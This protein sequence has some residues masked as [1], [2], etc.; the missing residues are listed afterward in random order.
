MA[1]QINTLVLKE[2]A[3]KSGALLEKRAEMGMAR[4]DGIK[5]IAEHK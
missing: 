3:Y 2:R 4:M 5:E 1:V